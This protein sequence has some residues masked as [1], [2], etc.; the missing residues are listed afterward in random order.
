MD[1]THTLFFT[2]Q[3]LLNTLRKGL[4]VLDEVQYIYIYDL[5]IYIFKYNDKLI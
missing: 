1:D 3:L 5:Y 2:P 4:I